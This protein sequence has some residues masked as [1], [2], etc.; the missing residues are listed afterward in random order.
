MNQYNGKSVFGGI[1]I[2][3]IKVLAKG[4]A[5][6]KRIHIDKPQEEIERYHAAVEEADRELSALYEKAL[7]EVPIN[8]EKINI[9]TTQKMQMI[10]I[11]KF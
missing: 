1:A 8:A 11:V 9:F 10:I 4:D 3:K 7:K 5:P 2:G 6:V